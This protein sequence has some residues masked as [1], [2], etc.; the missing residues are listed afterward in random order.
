MIRRYGGLTN[1]LSQH[2]G[3]QSRTT[4]RSSTS[5]AQVVLFKM[6]NQLLGPAE[7]NFKRSDL[8]FSKSQKEMEFD[9]FVVSHNIAFEYQGQQHFAGHYMWGSPTLVQ[10]RYGKYNSLI[11]Q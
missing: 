9:V 4:V 8:V 2:I 6:V 10:E 3:K 7:M 1:F 11:P 5:K